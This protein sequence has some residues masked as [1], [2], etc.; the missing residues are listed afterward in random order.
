[1]GSA[2]L[3]RKRVRRTAVHLVSP[4]IRIMTS[5]VATIGDNNMD[6]QGNN[7]TPVE[8]VNAVVAQLASRERVELPPFWAKK[9]KLSTL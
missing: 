5:T 6:N 1:M 3:Q 7:P 4:G 2:R 8:F 9:A